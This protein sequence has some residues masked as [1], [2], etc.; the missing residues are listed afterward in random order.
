M[1]NNLS[2]VIA[3][4][5]AAATFESL[6]PAAVSRAK[7]RL[8]DAVGLIAAGVR[9][10]GSQ[11][12]LSLVAG[13]GG[14]P[15]ATV[16]TTNQRVP[17]MNAAFANA[18]L[19]RSY[20]FEPVGADR[21]DGAQIPSHITGTTASVALAVGEAVGASGRELLTAMVYGD[22]LAARLGHATGFDVYGG[23]DNTGTI[24]VLGGTATAGILMGLDGEGLRRALGIAINQLGGTI[25]NIN[26][27]T[28][29][30]KLPIALSSRNAVFSSELAA[31]GFGGPDDPIGGR[32]GFLAQWGSDRSDRSAITDGLGSDFFADA[33]IK[34][35]P[36]CRASHASL[37]AAV[38]LVE[39]YG[40]RPD[41]VERCVVHVTPKTKAGFVGQ[42][43]AVGSS[44][45]VSGAFSIVF[46]VATALLHG[47]VQLQHMGE[48]HMNDPRLASMLERVE[49]E[50]SLPA[51]EV[52]TAEVEVWLRSGARHRV[53][54]E[55]VLGD[56]HFAPLTEERIRAK[57]L[58]NIAWN[59][60]IT[61]AQA[62]GLRELVLGIDSVD[63]LGALP[64]VLAGRAA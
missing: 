49:L 21:A 43:F 29:A 54:V 59:G 46:A 9:A 57:F 6:P 32:F 45:E 60:T 41:D 42:P 47:T 64:A 2:G 39:Q 58:S 4:H 56:I 27:K 50:A 44:P 55:Q 36:T 18:V 23:G 52:R 19:M 15:D 14:R 16:L 22:D 25:D 30:F 53:R 1:S 3:D 13:W 24:N 40:I 37:D 31:T 33:V 7:T 62:A 38:Q 63:D 61:E 5:L 11:E 10:Q 17:A 12:I 28:L 51:D 20:D 35:W 34:P 48:P 8:L 26:D